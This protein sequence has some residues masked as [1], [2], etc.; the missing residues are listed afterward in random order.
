[1][2]GIA[3]SL[4]LGLLTLD[5]DGNCPSAAE[6]AAALA[7]LLPSPAVR[8]RQH[9][10]ISS[11]DKALTL[12]LLGESGELILARQID[13]VDCRERARAVAVVIAAEERELSA[14]PPIPPPAAPT[15]AAAP[16]SASA[17]S[18][19][20]TVARR[21]TRP[22]ERPA[23]ELS[24][25]FVSSI[26]GDGQFAPGVTAAVA[27]GR[28]D[29]AFA[30]RIA[31]RGDGERALALGG[32]EA[33]WTRISLSAGA[34]YRLRHGRWDFDVDAGF[35]AALLLVQGSG[36]AD[37]QSA[38]NFDPGLEAGVRLALRWRFLTPFVGAA[39]SGW[40][41]GQ[42][43]ATNASAAQTEIPR[44]EVAL[45]VGAGFGNFR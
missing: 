29:G 3:L 42:Q 16:A 23:Y 37:D 27:L 17:D 34:L 41:R 8:A 25:A 20:V 14:L 40:L 13:E 28:H 21:P 11:D 36:Y 7:P 2:L 38:I 19:T 15:L 32:G 12:R 45:T 9:A 31:L 26:S 18:L 6:V 30:A 44:V 22:R 43:V 10:V 35:V 5:A 1:M 39:L 24:A 33:H 4:A